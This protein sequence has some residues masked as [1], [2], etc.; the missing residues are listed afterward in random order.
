MLDTQTAQRASRVTKTLLRAGQNVG[1]DLGPNEGEELGDSMR[2][3][4]RSLEKTKFA[5]RQRK[6][7]QS[8]GLTLTEES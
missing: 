8:P 5:H 2:V 7:D 4:R 6:T 1:S 3:R